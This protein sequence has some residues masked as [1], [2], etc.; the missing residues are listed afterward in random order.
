M[1]FVWGSKTEDRWLAKRFASQALLPAHQPITLPAPSEESASI[2][3][4][5]VWYQLPRR[6]IES[7]L[8]TFSSV[9]VKTKTIF[10]LFHIMVFFSMHFH[11]PLSS[12][13]CATRNLRLADRLLRRPIAI[14]LI[15]IVL[16]FNN[17]IIFHKLK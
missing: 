11:G 14:V 7:S 2:D 12:F 13:W 3:G 16:N 1:H 8:P 17:F 6:V 4:I 9:K 15:V 5:C 10:G